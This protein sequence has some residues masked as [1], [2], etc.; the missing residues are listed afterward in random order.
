VR[1]TRVL[2]PELVLGTRGSDQDIKFYKQYLN[3]ISKVGPGME[4]GPITQR[5]DEITQT[6]MALCWKFRKQGGGKVFHIG[7]EFAHAMA[8]IEKDIPVDRLPDKFFAYLSFPENT[9]T[10]F[11]SSPVMGGFIFIGP[12]KETTMRQGQNQEYNATLDTKVVWLNY[13]CAVP[14]SV[15]R[16]NPGVRLWQTAKFMMGLGDG[17]RAALELAPHLPNSDRAS[18]DVARAFI[19]LALYI[20][21]ADPQLLPTRAVQTQSITERKKFYV[22]HGVANHCSLPVTFVSWNYK[23]PFTY[24]KDMTTVRAHYRWQPCGPAFSQVKLVLIDEHER[25][26]KSGET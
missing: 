22:Q 13:E 5:M 6:H 4:C 19:N 8:G 14:E 20:H 3:D 23:Q 2:T 24:H 15:K 26:F 12:A 10:Q 7:R 25:H 16:T 1:L 21:S 9:F 11:E 17:T 18:T